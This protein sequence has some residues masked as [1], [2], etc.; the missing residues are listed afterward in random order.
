MARVSINVNNL[1]LAHRGSGGVAVASAPDVCLT[2]APPGPPVPVPYPNIARASDLAGGSKRV[3]VDGGN[4]AAVKG[5]KLATST[6]D[7]AGTTGGVASGTTK[8]KATWLSHS[9][10]VRIEGRPACRLTDKML[11]NSGNTVCCGGFLQAPLL[12]PAPPRLLLQCRRGGPPCDLLRLRVGET[13]AGGPQHEDHGDTERNTPFVVVPSAARAGARIPNGSEIG[14]TAGGRRDERKTRISLAV[15]SDIG[16]GCGERHPH[17]SVTEARTG[18]VVKRAKGATDVS[19]CV[20]SAPVPLEGVT[21]LGALMRAIWPFGR[22]P[23]DFDVTVD[24]CGSRAEGRITRRLET[25]VRAYPDDQYSLKLTL[26]SAAGA[27]GSGSRSKELATG[28]VT[29]SSESGRSALGVERRGRASSATYR[30]GSLWGK[31]HGSA[32]ASSAET[33]SAQRVDGRPLSFDATTRRVDRSGSSLKESTGFLRQNAIG[34]ALI[35]TVD[36]DPAVKLEFTHNGQQMEQVAD[37]SKLLNTIVHARQQ[38]NAFFQAIQDLTPQIGF[39]FAW[40][41]SVLEGSVEATW[42]YREHTDHRV[43]EGLSVKPALTLIAGEGELSFGVSVWVVEAKLY[44]KLAGNIGL[45]GEF[46]R[47]SPDERWPPRFDTLKG[48][49]EIT[50]SG[51]LHGELV[52]PKWA[53]LTA[54]L[55]STILY[56]EA[57]PVAA[58]DGLHLDAT[59]QFQG[60][61]GQCVAYVFGGKMKLGE[62]TFIEPAA[63]KPVRLL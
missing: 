17:V 42:G 1:S 31:Q 44:L 30:D 34:A 48:T 10:N 25:T 7:E 14:V 61:K 50:V 27:S 33:R 20:W 18:E 23:N 4:P 52:G 15:E 58:D 47:V 12:P 2:P 49:G 43:F 35:G 19:F 57:S 62:K 41:W 36:T 21:G 39:G 11:M 24:A 46:K 22:E 56:A 6:G 5:S 32:S 37:I 26:P 59:F 51:G 8:G 40:S 45:E 3:K 53:S 16:Y 9:F 63:K 60:L 55:S 13:H 54:S 38:F 28:D 29:R